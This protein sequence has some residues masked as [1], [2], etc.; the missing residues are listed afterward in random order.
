MIESWCG[1]SGYWVL[2]VWVVG[3]GS[4]VSI[5]RCVSRVITGPRKN[6]DVSE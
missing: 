6:R 3:S 5:L 4:K 2:N 1:D